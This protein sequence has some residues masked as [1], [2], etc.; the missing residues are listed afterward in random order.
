MNTELLKPE[1]ALFVPGDTIC[2]WVYNKPKYKKMKKGGKFVT[3]PETKRRKIG[4][5]VA[6]KNESG[7]I[8]VGW[9]RCASHDVF[10][11]DLARH[12]AYGRLMTGTNT[13]LPATFKDFMPEF[14]LR[15][16]KYFQTDEVAP[17]QFF[18]QVGKG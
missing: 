16:K 2:Q 12:I 18:S 6:A 8:E 1:D 10:D 9:S 5:V 13:D 4:Y 14:V 7:V 3:V 15:C 17:Y 11:A